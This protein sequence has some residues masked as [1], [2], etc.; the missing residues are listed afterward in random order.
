MVGHHVSWQGTLQE[1]IVCGV[2]TGGCIKL[3]GMPV[4][5]RSQGCEKEPLGQSVGFPLW[6]TS[7]LLG[8]DPFPSLPVYTLTAL[9][10]RVCA[11]V[12]VVLPRLL[13][14]LC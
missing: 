14:S 3:A 7:V 4:W 12:E 10:L 13:P 9:L 1:A 6:D 11:L 5:T 2:G 8:H